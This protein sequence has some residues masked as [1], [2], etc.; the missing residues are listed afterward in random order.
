MKMPPACLR[1]ISPSATESTSLGAKARHIAGTGSRVGGGVAVGG[2][3]LS[4]TAVSNAS[5]VV[6]AAC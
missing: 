1:V 2:V 4:V 5:M 3:V 6:I